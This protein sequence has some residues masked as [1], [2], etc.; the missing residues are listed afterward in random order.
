[1]GLEE[2]GFRSPSGIVGSV[3]GVIMA[4][5]GMEF[6]RFA[7]RTAPSL[8][9]FTAVH[10]GRWVAKNFKPPLS[11]RIRHHLHY[12]GE[13]LTPQVVAKVVTYGTPRFQ[14]PHL[15]SQGGKRTSV[16][17]LHPDGSRG[18]AG[19]APT[20]NLRARRQALGVLLLR[21]S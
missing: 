5:I 11:C 20:A 18:R 7:H 19:R 12:L 6:V 4:N 10:A 16:I 2:N 9:D 13:V 17:F 15:L 1:M 14:Y 21:S 3:L 8:R